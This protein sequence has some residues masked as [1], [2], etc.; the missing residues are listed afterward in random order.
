MPNNRDDF[1]EKTKDRMAKRVGYRCSNPN[2]RKLTCGSGT[3]KDGVV[4]IG[5]AAH[6][7]AAAPGGKRYD[8]NMTPEQ[9]KDIDNGIWLC[10]SC[11][12]LID[13]DEI[14]YPVELLR[15][16]KIQAMEETARELEFRSGE[17]KEHILALGHFAK[18]VS[19]CKTL[20]DFLRCEVFLNDELDNLVAKMEKLQ[21]KIEYAQ[22]QNNRFWAGIYER[23]MNNSRQLFQQIDSQ[24]NMLRVQADSVRRGITQ[25]KMVAQN[26]AAAAVGMTVG[27]LIMPASAMVAAVA[28]VS[29][30]AF[31][32][33]ETEHF[34][35]M[36]RETWIMAEQAEHMFAACD[37]D[38]K[39]MELQ[40]CGESDRVQ[41]QD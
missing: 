25:G 28:G 33:K 4:N 21:Q 37:L 32:Q 3:K 16:W 7:C 36:L 30:W 11:A 34:A 24:I 10:Q 6:I 8:P 13:S 22:S 12:K 26:T 17:G 1:T 18:T 39:K 2:C 38:I 19:E 9:R 31:L 27:A 41:V 20:E 14:R 23:Q 40:I 5:V 15:K 35:C 29:I